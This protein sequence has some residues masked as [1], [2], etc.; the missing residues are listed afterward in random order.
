MHELK[1]GMITRFRATTDI[2]VRRRPYKLQVWIQVRS[3]NKSIAHRLIATRLSTLRLNLRVRY[4]RAL[5]LGH[6]PRLRVPSCEQADLEGDHLL[7]DELEQLRLL[8]GQLVAGLAD[9]VRRVQTRH[10]AVHVR[11]QPQLAQLRLLVVRE[12][13]GRVRVPLH[14][15]ARGEHDGARRG[16]ARAR[17]V[18]LLEVREPLGDFGRWGVGKEEADLAFKLLVKGVRSRGEQEEG[19]ERTLA[20]LETPGRCSDSGVVPRA[21]AMTVLLAKTNRPELRDMSVME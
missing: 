4:P 12:R 9:F 3:T 8:R 15:G 16:V 1:V 13:L 19:R 2:A 14:D 10:A 5:N 17:E 6:L 20:S 18:G 21:F 7:P 11:R